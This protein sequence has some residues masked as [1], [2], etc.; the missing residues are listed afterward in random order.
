MKTNLWILFGTLVT[1]S[2]LAQPVTNEPPAAPITTPAPDTALTNVPALEPAA[3]AAG[4]TNEAATAK[5]APAKAPAKKAPVKKVAKKAAKP[6]PLFELK[7]VPLVAGPATVV[8]S[9][10][11]VR[12][13]AKLTSE[14]VTRVTKGQTVNV[15]EEVVIKRSGP[16]EPSAWARIA[17]PEAV[18][19]W[20]HGSY[21]DATNKTVVPKKL[22][23][24][25]GPGENYSVI[26]QLKRGDSVSEVSTRGEWIEIAAPAGA[27]AFIAAVFL[28]QE[29]PGA[30]PAI[31]A[32]TPAVPAPMPET[33]TEP[34]PVAAAPATT[35]AVPAMPADITAP[36]D[37]NLVAATSGDTNVVVEPVIEEPPPPRIVSREGVV[38]G[39]TSIQAPTAFGLVSTDTG[40]T[41]NYLY[42]S[43]SE[44]DLS[45]YKGLR[46]IVTGEESLDKRWRITPVI[47]I[48][49][50]QVLE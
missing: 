38:R 44:L 24:R 12:G 30:P 32:V 36:A 6:N 48:Q 14:I 41:I 50:I 4:I 7:T 1:T 33:V 43:S 47:N 19:A 29:A 26:G 35:P 46:I 23:I 22:N 49:K 2:L 39:T 18:H 8:A 25:T 13:Q 45:R 40:R 17:L 9:N 21:I 15:L 11:N 10:V 28:K 34:A 5:P 27:H 31:A 42:S 16:D 20:V 37:T 3:L